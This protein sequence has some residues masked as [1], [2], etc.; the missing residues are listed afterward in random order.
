MPIAQADLDAAQ[1][2]YETS[3]ANVDVAVATV[4]QDQANFDLAQINLKTTRPS[5]RP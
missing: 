3:K 4:A 1:A 2:L 5:N